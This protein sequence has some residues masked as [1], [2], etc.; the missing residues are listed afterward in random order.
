VQLKNAMSKSSVIALLCTK[1]DAVPASGPSYKPTSKIS[2][3][4]TY[5]IFTALLIFVVLCFSPFRV[6]AQERASIEACHA[7][8]QGGP[9][10][11]VRMEPASESKTRV[12]E[13]L[14]IAW[15][16]LAQLD[17]ACDTPF[18]LVLAM[19]QRVSFAGE[20][21]FVLPPGV[22]GPF[23]LGY[24]KDR[25]RVFVPLHVGKAV[26]KGQLRVAVYQAGSF[27]LDWKLV[28]VP[29]RLARPQRLADYALGEEV[30]HSPSRGHFTRFIAPAVP[31]IVS[32][33][34]F[35]SE[36]PR[37]VIVHDGA[38]LELQDFGTFH[39]I[40][41]RGSRD[42]VLEQA[43]TNPEFSPTGRFL[44]A[45]SSGFFVVD[46]VT[47]RTVFDLRNGLPNAPTDAQIE[48]L[49]IDW[50]CGDAFLALSAQEGTGGSTH[51]VQPLIDRSPFSYA[52]AGCSVDY[53]TERVDLAASARYSTVD[54]YDMQFRSI[55]FS[56]A[57]FY[58]LY[59]DAGLRQMFENK[60]REDLSLDGLDG[61]SSWQKDAID[62][63]AAVHR[64]VPVRE[65]E[66]IDLSPRKVEKK[67][68]RAE[69]P[70]VLGWALD[71]QGNVRGIRTRGA[72]R[73]QAAPSAAGFSAPTAA[74][75]EWGV[76]YES[77]IEPS[78]I[79]R[80][81]QRPTGYLSTEVGGLPETVLRDL[82]RDLPAA[83]T[84]MYSSDGLAYC[85]QTNERPAAGA[86]SRI[87]TASGTIFPNAIYAAWR[88]RV[89]SRP[90]WLLALSCFGVEGIDRYGD[91]VVLWREADGSQYVRW[92]GDLI[93]EGK[94]VRE[95]LALTA[96]DNP[97]VSV[98]LTVSGH[99]LISV[100]TS[101]RVVMV[102]TKPP[103]SLH[104][105][106]G[107]L[108]AGP[109]R[110][111]TMSSDGRR[112]IE[113]SADGGLAI[114]G[115]DHTV[116]PVSGRLIDDEIVLHDDRGYYGGSAEGAQYL[117]LKFPGTPG[118][119]SFFQFRQTLNRPDIVRAALTNSSADVPAPELP[120]PPT[121]DLT[122]APPNCSHGRCTLRLSIT[123]S[124]QVGL[125]RIRLF[126]DGKLAREEPV[127]GNEL[128]QNFN[129]ETPAGTRFVTVLAIDALGY[130][131]VAVGA[132]VQTA[133]REGG[134]GRLFALAVGTDNYSDPGLPRL[135]LARRDAA[136]FL[137]AIK[138][139]E[140]GYYRSVEGEALLD[141]RDLSVDLPAKLGRLTA[142]ASDG[143]T[144]MV[145]VAGHGVLDAKGQFWFATSRTK[146]DDLEGTAMSADAILR[147]LKGS[148]A[149]VIL[150]LDACH[151]G[152]ASGLAS[153]DDAARAFLDRSE[154]ISVIAASKGRQLSQE[155]INLGGGVFT[156]A[157]ERALV[158]D[159]S[160]SDTNGNGTIELS[161]LYGAVKRRV[162]ELTK[163]KQTPW[164][165]R[166]NMVGEIPLF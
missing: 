141:L 94:S 11:E 82:V 56:E 121:A 18:Y 55:L 108:P 151:A 54:R 81:V 85:S 35:S 34:R 62:R 23:G 139:S 46:L 29:K 93:L 107:L 106:D 38:G 53:D 146:L 101:S 48:I 60:Q 47:G 158:Q 95:L 99:L 51:F 84:L 135:R 20:G 30:Q 120:V 16:L 69:E 87:E 114:H 112:L 2:I 154:A 67:I 12:G 42:L 32:F 156:R 39:R 147:V 14:S 111:L 98:S 118:L 78:L 44:M 144:I 66:M 19:H 123:A 6:Y 157:I 86:T 130:E 40:V 45:W 7:K 74:L 124:T 37:T 155:R 17:A 4:K 73:L 117:F 148:K 116:R 122:L 41:Q 100:A 33:D 142:A 129:L 115:L 31:N 75:A 72:L 161:E 143:D 91:L 90:L 26:R 113:Q 133:A 138:T 9:M 110:L 132:P 145:F 8:A 96:T 125:K 49:G 70:K 64:L 43:G 131:S 68:G 59:A 165:A 88:W 159:R 76:E 79:S 103:S 10:I 109:Q 57:E 89:D 22:D 13:P 134:K 1:N 65:A 63:A 92:L 150:F 21:F 162:V 36:V 5:T 27:D 140:G 152:A 71:L 24:A 80:P 3:S 119:Y 52:C 127:S 61:L 25:M 50:A 136:T 163:G 15:E 149:R 164:I 166:N 97:P 153:A 58:R 126:L 102:G 77:L 128:S 28:E 104:L 83:G 137:K 105:L 160:Q